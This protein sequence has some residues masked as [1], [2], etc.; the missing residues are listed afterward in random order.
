LDGFVGGLDNA[1]Y[2]PLLNGVS[3]APDVHEASAIVMVAP[4]STAPVEVVASMGRIPIGR[5][6]DASAGVV[7]VAAPGTVD[8]DADA[9]VSSEAQ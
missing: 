7:P 4:E 9:V 5:M 3:S 8:A 2:D 6:T 1:G